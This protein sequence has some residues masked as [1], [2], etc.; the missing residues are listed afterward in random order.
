MSIPIITYSL[1][2]VSLKFGPIH[3]SHMPGVPAPTIGP[4]AKGLRLGVKLFCAN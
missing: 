1:V 4:M 3:S 2:N